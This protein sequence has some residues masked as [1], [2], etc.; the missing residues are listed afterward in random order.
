[1]ETNIVTFRPG[2]TPHLPKAD[3]EE[4]PSEKEKYCIKMCEDSAEE[5]REVVATGYCVECERYMSDEYIQAH[6]KTKLTK[7]HT[8]SDVPAPIINHPRKDAAEGREVKKDS[9][10]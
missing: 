7:D 6:K 5:G 10:G 4:D 9:E 1:M 3:Q 8:I 2:A